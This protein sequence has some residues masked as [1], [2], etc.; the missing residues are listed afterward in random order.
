MA[1]S[2]AISV[3]FPEETRRRLA[4]ISER[5]G[6]DAAVLIRKALDDYL[7]RAEQTGSIQFPLRVLEDKIPYGDAKMLDR[8]EPKRRGK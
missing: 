5:T 8:N 3:R 6:L 4:K 2:D 7:D 1:Y